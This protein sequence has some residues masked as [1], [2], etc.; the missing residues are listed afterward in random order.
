MPVTSLGC[1]YAKQIHDGKLTW[2]TDIPKRRRQDVY[3]SYVEMDYTPAI[4]P[5]SETD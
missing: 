2:E 1:K 3:D 5:P 4:N